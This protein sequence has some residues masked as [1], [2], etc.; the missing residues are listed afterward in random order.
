[1]FGGLEP[2]AWRAREREAIRG[3]WGGALSGLSGGRS[4]GQG[5]KGGGAKPPE[6][7]LK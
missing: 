1:M 4:P 3:V 2:E 5:V 6:Q 7:G